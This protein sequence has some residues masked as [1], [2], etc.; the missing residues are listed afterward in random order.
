MT[1]EKSVIDEQIANL[2]KFDK[3][4]TKKEIKYLPEI[5]MPGET[6]RAIT[7]GMLDGNSWLITVTDRRIVFL[8]KGIIFGLK[9][10]EFPLKQVSSI[11]HKI[12]LVTGTIEVSTSAGSK[13]IKNL[14]KPDT[15]K[16]AQIISDL[17]A[18]I[19]T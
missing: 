4:F 9:Q 6:I 17:V 18:S 19:P 7:S 3:L 11:T 14:T 10:I 16:V 1:V 13:K 12:G 5:I 8:D 2:G 15:K